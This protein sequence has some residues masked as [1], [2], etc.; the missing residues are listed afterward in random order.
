MNLTLI[1]AICSPYRESSP[2]RYSGSASLFELCAVRGVAV[3]AAVTDICTS[4]C[5]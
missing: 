5:I 1:A 4:L 2:S 3:A